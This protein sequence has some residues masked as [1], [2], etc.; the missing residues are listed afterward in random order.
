MDHKVQ[1]FRIIGGIGI[2]RRRAAEEHRF[3]YVRRDFLQVSGNDSG[4]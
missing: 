2:V 1:Q 4:V 3:A